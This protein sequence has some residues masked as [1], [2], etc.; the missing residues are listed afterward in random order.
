MAVKAKKVL[1]LIKLQILAGA[2]N[3]SPPIGP[4]LGQR[5]LNIMDF[6]KQFNAATKDLDKTLKVPV[7]ITA[8]VDK[9]FDFVYKSPPASA[10]LL[11]IA[12]LKSGSAVPNKNKVGK[13][14]MTQVR[15][16][17]TTKL[18]DTNAASIETAMKSIMGTARSMGLDVIDDSKRG[19]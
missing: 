17:A 8:Y 14:T 18:A 13:V 10:L 2:A 1:G 19:A 12:G 9:T 6:C 3:P 4:A 5:G 16:I 15:E 7:V 11:K